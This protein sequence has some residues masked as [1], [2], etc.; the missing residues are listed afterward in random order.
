[1]LAPIVLFVYNRPLHTG[2]TIE[3][4]SK[5]TLAIDSTLIIF[6]DAAKNEKEIKNVAEVRKLIKNIKGFKEVEIIERE[7]N[8]GLAKSVI[9]GVT[10]VVNK[11]NKVI[12]LEDDLVTSPY[13][14][15]YMNSALDLYEN[16]EDVISIH[17]YI[18]PIKKELP[19]TFFI[20]GADCWGWATWKRGWNIFEEDGES[21]LNKI[22]DNNLT[23]DFDFNNSYPYTQM[24]KDCVEGKNSSWAIR[25]YASA[26]LKNKLTLYPGKSLVKNIG[27]DGSGTH[28]GRKNQHDSR[29]VNKMELLSKIDIKEDTEARNIFTLYFKKI[30]KRS[31]V[32]IFTKILKIKNH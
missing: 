4:L 29:I 24:L 17:G 11:Y 8:I 9:A 10:N 13:F 21:L 23:K 14:L 6:S 25:W 12:V 2:Q 30:Q 20:K 31:L 7:T 32:S 5:N 18:Y 22:K 16:E 26:F 1:M 19:N 3:A 15:T 27:I 28:S